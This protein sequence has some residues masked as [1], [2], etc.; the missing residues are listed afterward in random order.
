MTRLTHD[1]VKNISNDL[2]KLEDFLQKTTGR[3]IK[4]IACEACGV[5]EHAVNPEAFSVAVVPI[6]SGLGMIGDFSESVRDIAK[7]LGF[8][9]TY[10]TDTT[11]VQGFAEAISK[12]ADMILMADDNE[13]IAYNTEEM[14]QADN[15]SCTAK[16]YISCLNA[17][18][19]SVIGREVLVVGA[20]RVGGKA[21][22]FLLAKGAKVTV[23]DIV[24]EKCDKVARLYP[25][26]KVDYDVVGAIRGADLIINASPAHIDTENIKDG[27]IISSPG[28]PHTFDEAAY[29]KATI[30]HDPLVIGVATMIMQAAFYS[31]KGCR[32]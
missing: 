23:T 13:F 8:E 5:W 12:K 31:Y 25:G 20:G 21:C 4:N 14:A 26:T 22:Q 3:K 10:V 32:R 1:D 2:S 11:D 18:A 27:A 29:A 30:I 24:S 15:S 6:T 7:W 16:G 17:C 9:D 19:E 28:V